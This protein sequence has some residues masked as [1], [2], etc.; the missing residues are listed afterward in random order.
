M[1]FDA[2]EPE[3]AVACH[4]PILDRVACYSGQS[5]FPVHIRWLRESPTQWGRCTQQRG[6]H[7]SCV[8]HIG[9]PLVSNKPQIVVS[10]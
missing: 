6:H 5:R 7:F 8:T 3:R 10:R 1:R 4:K 9:T 2:P